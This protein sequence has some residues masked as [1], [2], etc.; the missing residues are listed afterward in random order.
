ML[1][2]SVEMLQAAKRGHYAIPSPDFIDSNSSK[3]F[4]E[5]AEQL[6][7]PII[8]SFAEVHLEQMSVKEAAMIGRFYAAKA[9]VPVAL[10]LDHGVHMDVIQE[11]VREGFTSVMID[12]SGYDM[13]ENIRRTKE[14]TAYA[15]AHN[16]PVEAEI[17]HV[18]TE[19]TD[20]PHAVSA[21]IYTET[22]K[23]VEFVRAT[24]VDSLAVSI[25][26]SHGKYKGT[27]HLNFERLQELDEMLKVPLVLHGGSGTGDEN[28]L[29][30]A[31]MGICKVN[32]YTDFI[33]AAVNRVY[34]KHPDNWMKALHDAD[35]A[36]ASVLRLYYAVLGCLKTEK[37]T[38]LK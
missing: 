17:G 13:Q 34:E 11:A 35:D 26:T 32:L 9:G 38:D 3:V 4:A 18:G 10:H 28:L 15:H 14:V 29:H 27:P 12:A 24:G 5:T 19:E 7:C 2:S 1:V 25:G 30:C 36:M 6:Q 23:A 21:S 31:Q 37:L 20:G 8:L 33:L 16:V 22:D